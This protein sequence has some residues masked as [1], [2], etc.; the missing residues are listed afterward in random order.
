[1]KGKLEG[2]SV[3]L[4]RRE[5]KK[6]YEAEC[7]LIDLARVAKVTRPLEAQ[8]LAGNS[9]VTPEF[10]AWLSPLVGD[11]PVTERLLHKSWTR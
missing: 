8:F 4:L 3:A 5:G 7:A 6:R 2:G 1:M 11:L 9:D 10:A